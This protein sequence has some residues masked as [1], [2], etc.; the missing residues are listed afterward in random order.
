M[1]TVVYYTGISVL[2]FIIIIIIMLQ[3]GESKPL[4]AF[5]LMK[6]L[7]DIAGSSV[8]SQNTEYRKLLHR[9]SIQGEAEG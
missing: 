9:R 3:S 7:P 4:L 2:V 1:M 8:D 5:G 6:S